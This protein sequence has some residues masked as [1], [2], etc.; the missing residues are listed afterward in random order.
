MYS[1]THFFNLHWKHIHFI[2][3]RVQLQNRSER[4]RVV[5][6]K[7]GFTSL[8]LSV[9]CASV[10][11]ARLWAVSV[12]GLGISQLALLN[13]HTWHSGAETR[14]NQ[15]YSCHHNMKQCNEI[16]SAAAL[17]HGMC[18]VWF[19]HFTTPARSFSETISKRQSFVLVKLTSSWYTNSKVAWCALCSDAG[20]RNGYC[21]YHLEFSYA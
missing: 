12:L 11:N 4:L 14:G 17:K 5:H 15:L 9:I 3:I 7:H 20:K 13:R 16:P 19:V 1:I 10:V 2:K 6:F 18:L 21:I 8:S